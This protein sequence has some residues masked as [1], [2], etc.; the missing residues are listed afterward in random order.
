MASDLWL[1]FRLLVRDARRQRIKIVSLDWLEDSLLSS[2]RRPKGE[3]AYEVGLH[4]VM[5]QRNAE[6]T[7]WETISNRQ[8]EQQNV[9]Q[10]NKDNAI[11]E[12]SMLAKS[13]DALVELK[14]A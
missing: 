1:K 3:K 10:V 9:A 4:R 8:R 11:K 12:A 14:S 5:S 13:T 2:T 6:S 7:Q